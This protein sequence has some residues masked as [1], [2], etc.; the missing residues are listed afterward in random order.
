[1]KGFY[2]LNILESVSCPRRLINPSFN[3]IGWW[4]LYTIFFLTRC[5]SA[6]SNTRTWLSALSGTANFFI[7][8]TRNDEEQIERFV[9]VFL[10]FWW[11]AEVYHIRGQIVYMK[12]GRDHSHSAHGGQTRAGIYKCWEGKETPKNVAWE[13]VGH[14]IENI[15]QLLTIFKLGQ[16]DQGAWNFMK[17]FGGQTGV[18]N[19]TAISSECSF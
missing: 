17:R 10:L 2:P 13:L 15:D 9:V 1:M 18:R 16:I 14:Y 12:N 5:T 8:L 3:D 4:H 11:T 6:R 19:A 7:F